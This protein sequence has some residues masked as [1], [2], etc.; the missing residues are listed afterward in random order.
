MIV[1]LLTNQNQNCLPVACQNGIHQDLWSDKET[2]QKFFHETL[3]GS[4]NQGLNKE[5]FKTV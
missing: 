5:N 2:S 4:M 3:Y 1:L